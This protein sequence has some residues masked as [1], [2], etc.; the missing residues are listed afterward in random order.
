MAGSKPLPLRLAAPLALALLLALALVANF[1]WAASS[2]R[3][4]PLSASSS[5]TVTTPPRAALLSTISPATCSIALNEFLVALSTLTI[6]PL[7]GD[8]EARKGGGAPERDVRRPA[9]AAL[10]LGGDARSARAT[11]RRGVGSDWESPLRLR[12]I[13]G[14]RPCEAPLL[15]YYCVIIPLDDFLLAMFSRI[16]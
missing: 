12:R 4:S 13:R 3:V 1:L 11:P 5:R 6:A 8:A 15:V 9:G 16:T 10:G 14:H 7:S 2:R